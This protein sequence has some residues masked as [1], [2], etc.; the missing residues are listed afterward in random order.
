MKR[1]QLVKQINEDLLTEVEE[2]LGIA[3]KDDYQGEEL[4]RIQAV[5]RFMQANKIGVAD[6]I[7]QVHFQSQQQEDLKGT[8][9]KPKRRR[10]TSKSKSLTQSEQNQGAA[11][12]K[13]TTAIST[14][15]TQEIATKT[16]QGSQLAKQGA[17]AFVVGYLD[18]SATCYEAIAKNIGAASDVI[19]QISDEAAATALTGESPIS[20]LAQGKGE[21]DEDFL[22]LTLV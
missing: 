7:A 10:R 4:N 11:K 12:K 5:I 21:Q 20:V 17:A 19:T 2:S 1:T 6:A 15:A 9:E 13:M 3:Q 22:D 18:T 14:V 16:E 8:P